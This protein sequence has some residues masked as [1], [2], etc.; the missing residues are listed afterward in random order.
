MR[1]EERCIAG[2][3]LLG[4]IREVFHESAYRRVII[5][6]ARGHALI[7]IPRHEDLV[8]AMLLPIWA[9]VGAMAAMASGFT[10]V[11]ERDGEEMEMAAAE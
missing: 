2:E 3:L 10:L 6:D 1:T 11:I 9:A 5:R 4:T 7:E 8:G